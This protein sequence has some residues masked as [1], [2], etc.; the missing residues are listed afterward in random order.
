MTLVL[1]SPLATFAAG[2]VK[3]SLVNKT[4]GK[5]AATPWKKADDR[6]SGRIAKPQLINM[7]ATAETLHS[8]LQ[9]SCFANMGLDPVWHGEYLAGKTADGGQVQYG[10]TC[11]FASGAHDASLSIL[12][13]DLTPLTGHITI[14]GKDVLTLP[15]TSSIHNECPYFEIPN[16]GMQNA[17]TQN[18]GTQNAGMQNASAQAIWVVTARPDMLPYTPITRKEYLGMVI[19]DLNTTKQRIIADVKARTPVRSAEEQAAIKKRDL[20]V[21]SARYSGNELAMRTRN[22]LDQYKSDEDYLKENID[23][24][25]AD[26]DTTLHMIQGMLNHLA[27]ATLAAPAI[28]SPTARDFEGFRDGEP[29]MVMLVRTN[30]AFFQPG[31]AREKPQFFLITWNSSPADAEAGGLTKLISKNLDTRILKDMLRK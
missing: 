22:Y 29:G 6:I 13:N 14:D 19:G 2:P 5:T 17:D 9:D 8:F 26:V 10:I 1:A 23:V 3:D 12:V 18:A 7:K 24:A 20:D 30:P 27:P 15:T 16:A 25:T 31:A 11:D 28:V 4:N 21:L